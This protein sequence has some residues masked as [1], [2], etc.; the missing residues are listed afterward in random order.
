MAL[1]AAFVRDTKKLLTSNT[2]P[3]GKSRWIEH[4][5]VLKCYMRVNCSYMIAGKIQAAIVVSNIEVREAYRNKGLYSELLG[6]FDE[7]AAGRPI[8]IEGVMFEEQHGIYLRRGFTKIAP[9]PGMTFDP[10]TVCFY[11][12]PKEKDDQAKS[13]P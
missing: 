11:K 10:H 9:P 3:F 5:P 2:S 8:Y 7:C 12:L 6:I 1:P 4:E 13:S